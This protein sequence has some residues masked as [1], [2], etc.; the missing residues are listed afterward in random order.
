LGE[1]FTSVDHRGLSLYSWAEEGGLGQGE[2]APRAP[3]NPYPNGPSM[4]Y[5]PVPFLLSSAGYGLQI[6]GGARSEFHLGSE[7]A[8]AWRIAIFDT[9]AILAVEAHRSGRPLMIH[10]W[11][12]FPRREEAAAVDDAFFLGPALF[13]SRRS[14]RRDR[15]DRLAAAR[16]LCRSAQ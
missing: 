7:R 16:D 10:P 14:A 13:R 12:L 4:T 5:F 9:S 1:R 8:D 15:P 6:E 2:Q 3:Q 11:L